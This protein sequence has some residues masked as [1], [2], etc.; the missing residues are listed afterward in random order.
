MIGIF[1]IVLGNRVQDRQF[2]AVELLADPPRDFIAAGA[3][4]DRNQP[5]RAAKDLV[6][7]DRVD[8]R[9]IRRLCDLLAV[10]GEEPLNRREEKT[11]TPLAVAVN[12]APCGQALSPP[13]LDR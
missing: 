5:P 1:A 10:A 7:F 4:T 3:R 11:D 6:T 12:E 8:L 13:A 9:K 2:G